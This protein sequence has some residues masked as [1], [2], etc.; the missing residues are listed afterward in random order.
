MHTFIF[1]T[2]N[3]PQVSGSSCK[4]QYVNAYQIWLQICN[5]D[6]ALHLNPPEIIFSLH[7][8]KPHPRPEG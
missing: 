6:S 7:A 1:I 5:Q 4:A 2:V 8:W 3:N